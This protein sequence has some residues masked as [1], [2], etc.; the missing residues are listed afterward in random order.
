M[1]QPLVAPKRRC[2]LEYDVL[3]VDATAG[4]CTYK[5]DP[6]ISVPFDEIPWR[7]DGILYLRPE[8]QVLHKAA[9]L[10]RQDQQDFEACRPLLSER[11]AS[12]LREALKSTHP[13]H[14]WV[15][16]LA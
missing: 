14:P 10:R 1:Q 2:A 16:D 5:R 8:V 12:W 9:G 13:G 3:L 6:R 7:R 4:R 11:A 15:A